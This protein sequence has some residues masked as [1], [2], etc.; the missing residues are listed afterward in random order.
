MNT[1]QTTA[2]DKPID[3]VRVGF[4]GVGGMGNVHVQTLSQIQG[5]T[6]T[7]VCDP[8]EEHARQASS[9]ITDAG[10]PPPTLY[11]RGERDFERLCG[12]EDLD[13]IYTATPWEWHTPVCV[14]AMTHGKHAATEVP[15]AVT[16]DECWQ[17]VEAAERSGKHCIMM[18]NCC[19][20]KVELMTLNMV[21]KGL[22][23][24]LIHAECG[25]LHDLR[26]Y[27]FR[28]EGAAMWRTMHSIKR[29]GDLYPTHG[30][31]PV[32][33]CMNINRGNRFA[34][35][36]SMSTTANGLNL[37]AAKKFG[38]DSPQAK[39]KYAAGDV[40]TTLIQTEIGQTIVVKHDTNSPR[41][42]SRDI[43]VQ[44]TSGIVQK[45]PEEKIFVEGRSSGHDWEPF[46]N[47][48]TEFEHP[49]WSSQYHK[50]T[51]I[52]HGSID[53]IEDYRLIHCLREGLPLDMDVYDAAAWSAISALSEQSITAGNRPVDF[54][55]FTRGLWED[56]TP[57]GILS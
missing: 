4:V 55:D 6:I 35:L 40:V 54:P 13:I 56:R 7:A 28:N 20:D 38:P 43:C 16:L 3:H 53:Y 9:F 15:A 37:F 14:A 19:Y 57:L 33:Q 30:V 1:N 25:Y 18:E 12:E 51:G 41:P 31:G 24:D 10:D 52:G 29:N 21:R 49:L 2:G 48:Q 26:D 46:S 44:G 45:Y 34:H 36:V 32:A 17:L 23:G 42:Y 8:V 50:S 22:L 5:A 47:Y 39:Q 27:K 11:T